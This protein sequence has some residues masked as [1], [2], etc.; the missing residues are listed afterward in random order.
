MKA[1]IR[2]MI[3]KCLRNK[4]KKRQLD[5]CDL[6]L[7]YKEV[8]EKEIQEFLRNVDKDLQSKFEQVVLKIENWDLLERFF[9]SIMNFNYQLKLTKI[10]VGLR[11]ILLCASIESFKKFGKGTKGGSRKVFISFLKQASEEARNKILSL[12]EIK[13]DRQLSESERLDILLKYLYEKRCT[14]LHEG[15]HFR[16]VDEG[17]ATLIDTTGE[18]VVFFKAS[19]EDFLRLFQDALLNNLKREIKT[20]EIR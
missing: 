20:Y 12:F 7:Y 17:L 2:L 8:I 6:D 16:F 11:F 4:K 18:H 10:H 14:F 13:T 15:I 3:E 5:G 19:F 1:K 9:I